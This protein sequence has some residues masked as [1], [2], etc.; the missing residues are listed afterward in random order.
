MRELDPLSVLSGS[1]RTRETELQRILVATLEL[2]K[3]LSFRAFT[4]STEEFLES[5]IK[6]SKSFLWSA[7]RDTIHPRN[8]TIIRVDLLELV[9]FLVQFNGIGGLTR[10]F[11]GCDLLLET[12]VVSPTRGPCMAPQCRALAV[13]G[14]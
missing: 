5:P 2:R 14:V 9:Q 7:F 8:A 6:V 11:V 1:D 10:F 13:V 12:P 4:T 3:S